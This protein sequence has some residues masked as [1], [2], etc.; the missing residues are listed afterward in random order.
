MFN[1]TT[2]SNKELAGQAIMS[3]DKT[4]VTVENIEIIYDGYETEYFVTVPAGA[5]LKLK[6]IDI[7]LKS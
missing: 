3:A 7:N 5:E 2:G 1:I 4:S 6:S